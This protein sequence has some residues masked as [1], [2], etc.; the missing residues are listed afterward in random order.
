LAVFPAQDASVQ[1]PPAQL[2]KLLVAYQR[3]AAAAPKPAID[4]Q[5]LTKLRAD[6]DFKAN[7]FVAK[8]IV[9]IWYFSQFKA[10]DDPAAPFLDGGFYERGLVWPTVKAHAIGFSNQPHGYWTQKP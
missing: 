4:D 8:Q 5:L 3:L 7:E 1:P 9:N 2:A 10:V 6:P